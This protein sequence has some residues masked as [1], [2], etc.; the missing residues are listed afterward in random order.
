MDAARFWRKV[1]KI[2]G[3]CWE[4][5][6]AKAH[7]GYGAAWDGARVVRAHRLSWVIRFGAIPDG[8]LVLHRCDNPPCVNPDHLFLGTYADNM[9]DAAAKGRCRTGGDKSAQMRKLWAS[10]TPEQRAF[11]RRRP[12]LS[13]RSGILRTRVL[14][15]PQ[16]WAWIKA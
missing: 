13:E 14:L 6:A 3:G 15:L 8:M 2:D 10:L 1:K 5:Q 7:C 16:G 12:N 11:R 9:Q 4:W